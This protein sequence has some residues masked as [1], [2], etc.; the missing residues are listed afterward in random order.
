MRL[1]IEQTLQISKLSV[2]GQK[3]LVM[4]LRTYF[5]DC[6]RKTVTEHDF[7]ILGYLHSVL[8]DFGLKDV[9]DFRNLIELLEADKDK[10][11]EL[12]RHKR[13]QM[14]TAVRTMRPW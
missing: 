4:D 13:P 11:E 10:F 1:C 9:S 8:E 3:Q 12:A 7:V 14:M 5:V 2:T 6:L